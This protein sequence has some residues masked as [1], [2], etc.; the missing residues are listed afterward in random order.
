MS[1][2]LHPLLAYRERTNLKLDEL[3]KAA[4][5]SKST[6]SRVERRK[7]CPSLGLIARLVAATNGEVTANDFLPVPVEAGS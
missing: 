6:L 4:G 1:K 3:A 2:P 7:C 5:T